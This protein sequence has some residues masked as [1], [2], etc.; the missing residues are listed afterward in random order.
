M[1][2]SPPGA[3]RLRWVRRAALWAVVITAAFLL[4]DAVRPLMLSLRV[5]PVYRLMK[6]LTWI[7]KGWVL[8]LAAVI[9]LATGLWKRRAWLR[10][11]GLK[12]AVALAASGV[13][14][15]TVKHLAGRPRPKLWDR[16]ETAWGPSFQSGHDSFPSGHTI[17]AF[18]FAAVLAGVYPKGRWIWYLLAVL[19]GFTRLYLDAHYASDVLAAAGLGLI[20]GAWALRLRLKQAAT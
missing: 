19:V 14:V 6:I 7:G 9:L 4:D 17:S 11:A 20:C 15:Q 12:G 13:V 5:E 16:G 8:L 1:N 2:S 3:S 10:E 18:A